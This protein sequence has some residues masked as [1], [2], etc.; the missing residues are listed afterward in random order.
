MI[1]VTNECVDCGLPCLGNACPYRNVKRY[2]CDECKE[3]AKT[4][5]YDGRHLCIDCIENELLEVEGN[6]DF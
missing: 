6:E 4:Y 3:E 1:E 5:H 2:Y